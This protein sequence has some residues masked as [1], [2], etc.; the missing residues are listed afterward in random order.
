MTDKIQYGFFVDTTKCTGCK[1]CQVA[2]KDRSDLSLGVK[3]RR[4]YEYGGGSWTENEDGTFNN[5]V[6]AHYTS[7][8]CNHCSHP[9][10]VKACPTGACHKRKSDGLVHIEASLCVGCQSCSRACPYDAPQF[11]SERG[12]MTKCDGCYDRLEQGLN[13]TCVDSCPLRALEFG[14]IDELRNKH[15]DNADIQP[16]PS[17]DIT[18]PNLIIKVNRNAQPGGEILNEFE[19]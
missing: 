6:F 2:C 9:V 10:C 7:I 8:S 4:V 17:S 5:N 11:D 1:T 12:V 19:V 14:P 18:S 13:P 16:L 15:G 3:W